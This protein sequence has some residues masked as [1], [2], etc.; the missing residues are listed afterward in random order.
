MSNTVRIHQ[1]DEHVYDGVATE[2]ID[3]G[4]L[5]AVVGVDGD[6][7]QFAR[8]DSAGEKTAAYFAREYSHTGMSIEDSYQNGDHIEVLK[9]VPGDR[10]YGFLS[11]EEDVDA[12][13]LLVSA[14]D[15]A[16][17]EP[18][19]GEEA[20][21]VGIARESVNNSEAGDKTRIDVEVI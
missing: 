6:D 17:G 14:G 1:R 7:L 13:D 21:A 10:A 19:A 8:H 15:G 9:L 12:G 18:A 20:H 16:L 2:E 5:V 11:D 3:P 4:D